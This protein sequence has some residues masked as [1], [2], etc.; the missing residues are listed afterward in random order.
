MS[1]GL[2]EQLDQDLKEAMRHKDEVGKRVIR[3]AKAAILNRKIDKKAELTEDEVLAVLQREVKQRQDAIASVPA[4]KQ[5]QYATFLQE[6]RE[7]IAYLERYLPKPLSDEELRSL[8][9]EVLAE[10]G[11]TGK[12]QMGQAMGAVMARV[13]GRADGRRVQE[14]V[15]AALSG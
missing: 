3:M 8:V 11:I 10:Q 7:E 15:K 4:D 9:R 6:Q 1:M 12:N 2:A 13:K 5:D 14:A